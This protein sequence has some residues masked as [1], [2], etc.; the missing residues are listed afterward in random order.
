MK[1]INGRKFA[2]WKSKEEQNHFFL[3]FPMYIFIL[4]A[5]SSSMS[6]AIES[7]SYLV[8]FRASLSL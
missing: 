6:S 1:D 7:L 2:L 8:Q 3:V 5:N 4:F